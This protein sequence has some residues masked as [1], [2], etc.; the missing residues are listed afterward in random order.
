[1]T[2]GGRNGTAWTERWYGAMLLGYPR[3][4]RERHGAELIGTLMEAHPSRRRPS[5]RESV[6]LVDAGMLTRLRTRVGQ[7]PAWVDGLQ[8]GL[9]LLIL[10]QVASMLGDLAAA[11]QRPHLMTLLPLSLLVMTAVL[12]GRMGIAA[13]AATIAAA[14]TTYQALQ[15]PAR[16]TDYLAGFLAARTVAVPSDLHVWVTADASRLWLI[17]AGSAVLALQ[18]RTA[19][20]FPRRSWAWLALPLLWASFRS[21]AT[22]LRPVVSG[23]GVGF[24]AHQAPGIP[25]SLIFVSVLTLIVTIGFLLLAL[26]ATVAIGDPRWAIAAGV[27]LIPVGVSAVAMLVASPGAIVTLDYELPTVLLAAA[28]AVVLMRRRRRRVQV[29]R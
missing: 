10:T 11:N 20:P 14:V 25:T 19:G 13:V 12:M 6:R 26:R 24:P 23:Q 21:I 4:Y 3:Q 27:Y 2:R 17:A 5:L 16:G 28:C 29:D 22:A 7:V 18:R 9:L 15:L 8:L 1:M